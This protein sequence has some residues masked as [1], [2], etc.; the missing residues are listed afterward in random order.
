MKIGKI[1]RVERKTILLEM[2]VDF[3]ANDLEDFV[4]GAKHLTR[5]WEQKHY[6]MGKIVLMGN[7][8]KETKTIVIQVE[9][10]LFIEE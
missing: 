8:D 4:M 10:Q 2:G 7:F 3:Q 5:E 9:N 1:E 6:S